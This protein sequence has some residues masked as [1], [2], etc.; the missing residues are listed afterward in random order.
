MLIDGKQLL[1]DFKRSRYAS[2]YSF[3]F[4]FIILMILLALRVIKCL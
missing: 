1:I 4:L 2:A 3:G